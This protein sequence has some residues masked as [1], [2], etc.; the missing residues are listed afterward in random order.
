MALF[1]RFAADYDL[2]YETPLGREVDRLERDLFNTI[3]GPKPGERVLDAGCGTGRLCLELA[4]L[5]LIVLGVDISGKMLDEARRKTAGYPRVDLIQAD[6]NRIPF[7]SQTFD[8]VTAFTVLEFSAHQETA[9]RELW[10]LVRPKGRLVIAVLNAYSPWAV[11][12]R[13]RAAGGESVFSYARFYRPWEL[14]SLIGRVTGEERIT[15]G[16]TVFI[17]PSGGILSVSLA[18]PI[19]RVGRTVLK[20]FGALL[21]MRVDKTR[22]RQTVRTDQ[23]LPH[24]C[25]EAH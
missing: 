23:H 8:L 13:R 11:H 9:V 5:G 2:W 20:P 12:R 24:L 16:S 15:W 3:A 22:I 21:V 4:E 1:D 19:D 14:I 10:R 18:R 6:I 25:P 7:P 17:P